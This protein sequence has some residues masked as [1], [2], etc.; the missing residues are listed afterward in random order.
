MRFALVL[1]LV[2]AA[3]CAGPTRPTETWLGRNATILIDGEAFSP[4]ATGPTRLEVPLREKNV[5]RIIEPRKATVVQEMTVLVDPPAEVEDRV[6]FNS[7]ANT[8]IVY[9][10][11]KGGSIAGSAGPQA[12]FPDP[13]ARLKDDR[14]PFFNPPY[15]QGVLL[16]CND[17]RAIVT[18]DRDRRFRFAFEPAADA[19]A[20]RPWSKPLAIE[21]DA[22]PHVVEVA[23][24]GAR[25]FVADV[26]VKTGEYTYLGVRLAEE[27]RRAG[28][29]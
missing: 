10:G 9:T 2:L 14:G 11:E 7:T 21:L 28:D 13:I 8:T 29:E 26:L 16:T 19:T 6:V 3:G 27:R 5:Y 12:L 17:H 15:G 24:P 25:P 22:G 1:V 4:A 18:L 23:R 20:D